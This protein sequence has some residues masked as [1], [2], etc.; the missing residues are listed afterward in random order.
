MWKQ[1]NSE[2][3][4]GFKI[5]FADNP[6]YIGIV[7]GEIYRSD[8]GGFGNVWGATKE[9]AFEQ[10]KHYIDAYGSQAEWTIQH[11]GKPY[12]RAP[13]SKREKLKKAWGSGKYEAWKP[14]KE[15]GY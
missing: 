5:D 11:K 3:Y 6:N 9:H 12:P 15:T 10:A 2:T 8:S 4:R 7:V 1:Y 14:P 13:E